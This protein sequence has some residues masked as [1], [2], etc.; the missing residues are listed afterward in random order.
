[1]TVKGLVERLEKADRGTW[2]VTLKTTGNE[3]APLYKKLSH[4]ADEVQKFVLAAGFD[5]KE[6]SISTPKVTDL[7]AREYGTGTLAP[8]R[9]QVEYMV[10]VNSQKV[11]VLNTL[12]AKAGDLLTQGISISG[13][14]TKFYLDR[15]NELRPQL[16]ADSTQNAQEVAE[17]FAKTTGSHIGGI[18]KANQ[19]AIRVTSPDAS[20]NNE[21]DEG[22]AS[23]MKKVR[24]VSTIEFYI[25]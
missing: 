25:Q 17:G 1:M 6:I 12:S 13:S 20:P 23:L 11:D 4:D 10:S 22:A 8:E 7:H 19:G 3:L 9:Y 24:L 16:I 5:Q 18:R 15:F 2:D 14:E 21:Y